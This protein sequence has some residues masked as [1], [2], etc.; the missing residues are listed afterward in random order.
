M[1]SLLL[2]ALLCVA[3]GVAI[4][5]DLHEATIVDH[6]MR[7]PAYRKQLVAN[8]KKTLGVSDALQVVEEPADGRVLVLP[9]FTGTQVAPP[10][11][12]SV[13]ARFL[14]ELTWNRKLR[15]R[16]VANWRSALRAANLPVP[17][18]GTLRVIEPRAGERVI[19]LPRTAMVPE[20]LVHSRAMVTHAP[21]GGT[22]A[23]CPITGCEGEGGVVDP[24]PSKT[25]RSTILRIDA[26]RWNQNPLGP[27][28]KNDNRVGFQIPDGATLESITMGEFDCD[29]NGDDFEPG[30]YLDT[31]VALGIVAGGTVLNSRPPR[32]A[33]G[34]QELSYHWWF[35]QWGHTQAF[36][37]VNVQSKKPIALDASKT[38]RFTHVNMDDG[39]VQHR[40]KLPVCFRELD[41]AIDLQ[42]P[43]DGRP[44]TYRDVSFG[45][46]VVPGDNCVIEWFGC[47]NNDNV[48]P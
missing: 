10:A 13:E 6:A 28:C 21:G 18:R 9:P 41:V 27:G 14:L 38:N 20:R 5:Q 31:H 1:R 33:T 46:Q 25:Y 29:V 45:A 48:I 23:L 3:P 42:G 35:N 39:W 12:A 24:P 22:T 17:E 26:K 2:S 32:G 7:D 44:V 43:I 11:D 15:Q 30:T 8:P 16:V 47:R 19:V 4:A 37:C 40:V 36:I 34:T